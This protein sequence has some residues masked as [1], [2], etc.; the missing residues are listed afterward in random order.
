MW[1]VIHIA[2]DAKAAAGIRSLLET[3]GFVVRLRK[4]CGVPPE[5]DCF[6]ALVLASEAEEAK[7]V[8]TD[9]LFGY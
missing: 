5:P 7:D 6:E 1:V 9:K 3:E 8:L 2:Q 4:V